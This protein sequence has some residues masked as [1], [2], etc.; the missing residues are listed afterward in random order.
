LSPESAPFWD[1]TRERRLVIQWCTACSKPIFFPRAFCPHCDAPGS[2]L[3]WRE[4]NGRGNV[5]AVTVEHRPE[6]MGATEPYAVA[7]VE[8][9]EGVRL[10]G[11]IVNCPLDTV[12]VKMP[13]QITWEALEDGRHLP[14]FEP[15]EPAERS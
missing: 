15:Q 4:S 9:E 14:L 7:L 11:N 3:E 2:A 6:L 1:A 8:L 5:Y 12:A 13:V 10:V